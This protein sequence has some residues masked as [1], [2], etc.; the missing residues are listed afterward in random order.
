MTVG[1]FKVF[2]FNEYRKIHF[3]TQAELAKYLGLDQSTISN[4]ETGCRRLDATKVAR[5]SSLTGISK[6]D[7]R[8]DLF[9]KKD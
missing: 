5:V 7:L 3:L 8:P 6:H 2:A 4:L 9:E 1:N